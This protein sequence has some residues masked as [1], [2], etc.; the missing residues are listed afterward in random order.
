[1]STE[2]VTLAQ[3]GAPG[4]KL[5]EGAQAR[6]FALPGLQLPDARGPFVF[7]QYKPRQ[8]PPQGLRRLVKVRNDLDPAA[9]GRLD[10]YTAWPLR[11]V[12]DGGQVCGVVMPLI[13]QSFLQTRVLPGT[14]A[15]K[16]SAREV[17]NLLVTPERARVVGMPVPTVGDRLAICR[18]LAAALH[19]LHRNN[20]VFGDLNARNELF[21]IGERPAVML[22][23]C[24]GIRISGNAAVVTQLDAPDWDAPA[25]ERW[26][27]VYTDRYKLG[28][29]VLRCLS[30]GEQ[31]STTRDPDRA[32]A[33][34]DVE[35]QRLL[36]TAL[37]ADPGARP[38]AQD[39]GWYLQYRLTGLR[40]TTVAA[41]GAVAAVRTPPPQRQAGPALT[42]WVRDQATGQWIRR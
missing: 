33:A 11:V 22:V 41:V 35:G 28:L 10:L 2:A 38:T 5:G 32:A 37:D 3:L 21:R 36:R 1:M 39:W 26:L 20:L 17:Q 9:K 24:D 16:T 13:P 12:E 27:T 23:D 34:L 15:L 31:A 42:G 14:G 18:D 4:P 8:N 6:V 25:R 40:P 7:K 30:E 19:L 29:F